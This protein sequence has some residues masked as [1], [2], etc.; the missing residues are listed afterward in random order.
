[1][2]SQP[3]P[4][5]N[6]LQ[7]DSKPKDGTFHHADTGD[8]K[9]PPWNSDASVVITCPFNYEISLTDFRYKDPPGDKISGY[10]SNRV[11]ELDRILRRSLRDFEVGVQGDI[12]K[13]GIESK[14]SFVVDAIGGI[15]LTESVTSSMLTSLLGRPSV[16]TE[17]TEQKMDGISLSLIHA[18]VASLFALETVHN[19]ELFLKQPRIKAGELFSKAYGYVADSSRRR[20]WATLSIYISKFLLRVGTDEI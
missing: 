8:R 9:Y 11:A 5:L 17:S 18:S 15:L 16:G 4:A 1:V 3:L 14:R 13:T 10:D 6:K 12:D 19:R 20:Y 2:R 7:A